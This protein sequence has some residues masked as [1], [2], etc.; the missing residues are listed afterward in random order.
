MGGADELMSQ[1]TGCD[2]TV[3]NTD[4]WFQLCRLNASHR[5]ILVQMYRSFE[6]L[7]Q[8]LGL[9]PINEERRTLWIEHALRQAINCGGFLA[10]GDL[11][12][13]SF[14]ALAG[15]GEAEIAVF[16]R[17]E[18]RRRGIG[19]NL[20]GTI[21]QWAARERVRRITGLIAAQNIPG[22]R[23]LKGCGFR[24]SQYLLPA[25]EFDIEVPALT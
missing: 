12:G 23:L 10:T 25:I 1:E 17:Q 21:L 14:L 4:D 9:P 18:H 24:F 20:I 3:L 16:V 2:I 8:A 5:E 11:V 7:G 22:E 6:P 19:T 13:H 15:M